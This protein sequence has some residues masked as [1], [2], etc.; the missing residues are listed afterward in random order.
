MR[1]TN[2][3]FTRVAEWTKKYSNLPDSYIERTMRQVRHFTY[4][5]LDTLTRLL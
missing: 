4:F 1:L 2:N 5:L 3:L